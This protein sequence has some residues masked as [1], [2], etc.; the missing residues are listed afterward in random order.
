MLKRSIE[1]YQKQV[2]QYNEYICCAGLKIS[3]LSPPA[4]WVFGRVF[5]QSF[6]QRSSQNYGKLK[7]FRGILKT[8]A[9]ERGPGMASK[10][11][12]WIT[13]CEMCSRCRTPVLPK[14]APMKSIE[15]RQ[16]MELWAMDILGLFPMTA[17]NQYILVTSDHFTKWV[18]AVQFLVQK[19]VHLSWILNHLLMVDSLATGLLKKTQLTG[20]LKKTQ[21]LNCESLNS[22]CTCFR[23]IQ[24]F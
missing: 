9:E 2:V 18:E 16:P 11:Q 1:R 15:V 23:E 22:T 6:P 14:K 13:E 21:S 5:W 4:N 8:S 24:Q 20:S 12:L 7:E 17:R 10:V 19:Q 3:N